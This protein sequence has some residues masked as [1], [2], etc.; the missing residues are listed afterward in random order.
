MSATR[1][2]SN[3]KIRFHA[4]SFHKCHATAQNGCAVSSQCAFQINSTNWLT[5]MPNAGADAF[6]I[7]IMPIANSK[8]AI[9]QNTKSCE[10]EKSDRKKSKQK[11][12]PLYRYSL[13]K[14]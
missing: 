11:Q 6:K 4:V 8:I 10:L 9:D 13:L 3:D 7:Y 14:Y 1:S 2:K 5:K 12:M